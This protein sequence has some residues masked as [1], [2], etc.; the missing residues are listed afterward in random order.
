MVWCRDLPSSRECGLDTPVPE[1][2]EARCHSA[3]FPPCKPQVTD[4]K[5]GH[6]NGLGIAGSGS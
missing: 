3:R 5:S 2:G 1:S 4:Q 6:D